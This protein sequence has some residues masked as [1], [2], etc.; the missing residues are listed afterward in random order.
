MI[1][2]NESNNLSQ[3]AEFHSTPGW[4]LSLTIAARTG[5]AF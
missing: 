5:L 2:K 1:D 4:L 3:N